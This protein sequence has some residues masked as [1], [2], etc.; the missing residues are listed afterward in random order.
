MVST[1]NLF[2]LSTGLD[3]FLY[4]GTSQGVWRTVHGEGDG[5]FAGGFVG[6]LA[7]LVVGLDGFVLAS[8]SVFAEETP[9]EGIEVTAL[10]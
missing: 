2:G 1:E 10:A 9:E 8:V 4:V 7:V 5:Y 3:P 6:G